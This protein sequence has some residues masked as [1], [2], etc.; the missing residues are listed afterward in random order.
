MN[1]NEPLSAKHL[2]LSGI[3]SILG[4]LLVALSLVW[5][6]PISTYVIV[7]VGGAFVMAGAGFFLYSF[8]K[9]LLASR[10]T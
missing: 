2:R 9:S 1:S 6:H 10:H 8:V 7:W 4:L 3:L 5:N